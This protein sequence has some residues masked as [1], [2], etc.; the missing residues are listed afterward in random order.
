MSDHRLK[1]ALD[2][3]A[4]ERIPEDINLWPKI[5]LGLQHEAVSPGPRFR[6]SWSLVFLILALI[7]LTTVAYALYR[8]FNDP[9]M[10]SV[11]EAGLI[12]D[13]NATAQ[14][15][16]LTPQPPF[17]SGPGSAKII[18]RMESLNG[19]SLTLDWVYLEDSRQLFHITVEGLGSEMRLGMPSVS[20]PA[21]T[22]EGYSGA[23][24]S[25]DG[26]TTITGTYLSNQ[27]VR[28]NGQPGGTVDMQIDIPLEQRQDGQPA[29]LGD[30][31]FDLA[32][33]ELTVPWGGGGGN[34]YAV[35]VNGLEMRQ[36]YAIVAPDYS[37]VELCYQLP[38]AGH[39]WV[40]RDLTAQYG[41]QTALLGEPAVMDSYT[42]LADQGNERCAEVTFPLAQAPGSI[43]L[44]VTAD[45]L[46]ARQGGEE[47]DSQWVFYTGLVDALRIPGAEAATPTPAAPLA[48]ETIGDLTAT[49]ESAYLDANRMAFT[50]HFDGWKEGYGVGYVTR[51]DADGHAAVNVSADFRAAEG[52][53]STAI[54]SLTPASEY[55]AS[56]F[57][58]R[59]I[60]DL[61]ESPTGGD[62]TLEFSFDL[63]LP[64]Y[65][66]LTLQ[67]MQTET[68]GGLN[69]ILQ[70][71]KAAPSYTV[72]YLC[73]QKP[74]P[75]DWMLGEGPTLRIG[76]DVSAIGTYMMLYDSDFGAVG[77]AP[78]PGW[79]P[80]LEKGR[81]VKAGFPVG[82]RDQPEALILTIPDLQ[83]S[84]PEMVPE[85]EVK[86][87]QQA[88]Q[89][90]GIEMD[91]MTFSGNGGGG[92]GPVYRKL[93]AG[94]TETEAYQRFVQALGYTRSGPWVFTVQLQP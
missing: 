61:N 11:Q 20:Y 80:A 5:S 70:T 73:Y 75:D 72:V 35:R 22:P 92:G 63:D 50:V 52:D 45:G 94:M 91:W 32:G 21:V 85:A 36:E 79:K 15:D 66:A 14:S 76:E 55:P 88:L 51:L 83:R 9:G 57:K 13:V 4:Q 34:S 29:P 10:R 17:A 38:S 24:L 59:L 37:E 65:P 90:Q 86:K 18:G 69:M 67:P 27:L 46:T 53:P 48:S 54:I 87:A 81:C 89:A 6:L 74:T 23:I 30:F 82:H 7:L 33:L 60:L 93:P 64:V 26:T 19:V 3:L 62:S 41:G 44:V 39:D 1:D 84:M 31:H 2:D 49:L 42:Q 47:I 43:I 16:L 78:E 68:A 58:G 40:I 25:L 12:Q 28:P 8:Y 56:R 77:K 71:V